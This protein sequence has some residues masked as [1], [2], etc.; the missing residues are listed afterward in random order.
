MRLIRFPKNRSDEKKSSLNEKIL[1][2]NRRLKLKRKRLL[3]LLLKICLAL[4]GCCFV[5]GVRPSTPAV[6]GRR[7]KNAENKKTTKK[8]IATSS[9][10]SRTKK[11]VVDEKLI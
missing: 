9:P 5:F 3:R 6:T 11:Y 10:K 2:E 8:N 4:G 7:R 1:I